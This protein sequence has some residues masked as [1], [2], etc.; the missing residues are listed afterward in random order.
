MGSPCCAL[1]FI[2]VISSSFSPERFV[3]ASRLHQEQLHR[4]STFS[5]SCGYVDA[6]VRTTTSTIN[7]LDLTDGSFLYALLCSRH[8]VEVGVIT[9]RMDPLIPLSFPNSFSSVITQSLEYN[10]TVASQ[11]RKEVTMIPPFHSAEFSTE[12]WLSGMWVL[13]MGCIII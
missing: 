8:L 5:T 6:P 10:G 11:V 13:G 1:V 2:K 9:S 3:L 4:G 7:P 12:C